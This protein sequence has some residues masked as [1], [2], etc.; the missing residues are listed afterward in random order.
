MA[1]PSDDQLPFLL[2]PLES[3]ERYPIKGGCIVISAAGFETRTLALSKTIGAVGENAGA[4]V[5]RYEP[6]DA[7][8]KLSELVKALRRNNLLLDEKVDII[9]FNRFT[10]DDF[11]DALSS[12][13]LDLRAESV[14]LDASSMSKMALLLT[15]EVCSELNVDLSIFYA[16]ARSY[17]P[18]KRA[19]IESRAKGELHQPSIQVYSGIGEVVRSARLSSV[20]MQGEPVAAVMFMS[21]NELLTQA[22]LNCV[23]P[24][25]LFLINGRPPEHTWREEA[26]AWIHE[27]LRAEWSETDN[28]VDHMGLPCRSTSTLLYE[29]TVS[30]L[31]S[32]YW[33]LS[34]DYRIILAPT[35][36]KMQTLGLFISRALHPDI[37]VE[38]PTPKG[39]LKLYTS[40]VGRKWSIRYGRLGT[41]IQ[42]WRAQDKAKALGLAIDGDVGSGSLLR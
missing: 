9:G 30:A 22:L 17:G 37:H 33:R 11:G 39:Y 15:L 14:L 25:R 40:G 21:F 3:C 18:S 5:I 8:N 32:L 26:T 1:A 29:E 28:P 12:R 13:L 7:R 20:A 34:T 24:S 42:N 4:I 31:L 38:Y 6:G 36:S 23:Y 41:T 35:G 16:E 10:P 19:Y 2:P 27:R